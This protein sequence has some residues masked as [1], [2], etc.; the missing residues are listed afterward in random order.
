MLVGFTALIPIAGGYIAG[1]AGAFMLFVESPLSALGFVVFLLVLQQIEGNLV[2][3]RVV[4]SSI[5]LPGV[6]V[7]AA[8]TLGGGVMGI[9]GMLIGVPMA[10]AAYRL[11]SRDA[12][13]RKQGLSLFDMPH[14]EK[15]QN[16]LFK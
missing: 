10:S 3:P 2:F 16:V 5:G 12:R 7:L 13:A 8:V 1:A 6:W 15:K 4:G 9:P 11:L 14:D